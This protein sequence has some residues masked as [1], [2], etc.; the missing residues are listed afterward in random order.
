MPPAPPPDR[1]APVPLHL[2]C[3]TGIDDALAIAYL[4][5]EPAVEL[6][7]VS[8][9]SGNTSAAQAARNTLDLL[10]L[11]GRTD[12]PV[13]V[14]AAD[15]LAARFGGGAPAVHGPNGIGGVQLPRA[16]DPAGIPGPELIV[17]TA[18]EH[19]GRLRLLAIGPATNLA[20]ALAL[21]PQ[22][23][24][25][26]AEVT[27][28]GGAAL[29]PGN[30]TPVAEANVFHDPEA[31]GAVLAADW[32][33]TLV[34][35]DATMPQRLEEADRR[36]LLDEGGPLARAVGQALDHYFGAYAPRLGRRCSPIHDPLAAAVAAGA[37]V[38]APA[39]V[40]HVEVDTGRG[41]GRGQVIC[42]LRGLWSGFPPQPGAHVRVVLGVPGRF[43]DHLLPRVLPL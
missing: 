34:T 32:P 7:G 15:P 29:V 1:H 9:V 30:V 19:P 11:G 25:L 40:V 36:R 16:G 38:A 31:A 35:T 10:A 28:M 18:R 2:D 14:G 21:E 24:S 33:V 6:V 8:T 4:L 27:L 39:P 37:V 42:D 41:P 20:L 12:V 23:P 3:D 17:R 5:A 13:A 26:V 43:A 22:L